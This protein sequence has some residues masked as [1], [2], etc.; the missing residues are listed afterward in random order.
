MYA[1]VNGNTSESRG[2]VDT[3]CRLEG[4]GNTNA[5]HIHHSR[6]L[7][8]DRNNEVGDQDRKHMPTVSHPR[9]VTSGEMNEETD[10]GSILVTSGDVDIAAS[11]P[12]D[13]GV[14][15]AA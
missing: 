13:G 4:G 12:P 9:M 8:F 7:A 10:E 14:Q 11:W 1:L 15:L 6:T 5:H 2:V 3:N